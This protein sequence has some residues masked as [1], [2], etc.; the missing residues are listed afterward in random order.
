MIRYAS[1]RIGR[2]TIIQRR[3]QGNMT[4]RLMINTYLSAVV[5]RGST[6]RS[7]SAG[8]SYGVQTVKIVD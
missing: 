8:V 2:E 1:C 4:A 7:P 5:A 6:S 3:F